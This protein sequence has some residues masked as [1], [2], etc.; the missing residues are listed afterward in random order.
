MAPSF[1]AAETPDQPNILFILADDLAWSDLGCYGHPWHDTPHLD[2]LASEGARFTEAYASAPIC[3]ASRASILTGKTPARLHF[4]FVT[5]DAAGQQKIDF[6]TPL[7]APP[8]TLN[9]PLE[10]RTI[11][12]CLN[13]EGYQTAFFG[14][15]HVSSHHER[16]LGWSP[17]HGPK[18][19]GFEVAEEDY[20]AHPYN[21]KR[22]PV[23]TITEVGSF[24]SDSMVDRVGAF[25]RKKHDRPYFAMASSFY[26][27]TPVRTPCQWLRKKYDAR[28]PSNSKK[29]KNRI[30]YAAFVET[31][32]HHV[33]QI[34]D[35]LE[36][37]GEAD[38]TIVV[39]YS[40]NGGHP[41]YTAN[42]P[43]RGSKWNLYEGGIRVPMIVRWPGVVQA[44][45]EIERP[46]IGVDLLPTMVDWA[47]GDLPKCD[48]ESVAGWMN[49]N[50]QSAEQERSLI[51]HFPYYHPEK[52][53]AKAPDNIGI[54][55]FAT[56]RT[57]PQSAI[58]RGQY[59]L[60]QFAEDNRVELYDLASDI[61]EQKDLSAQ[62]SDLAAKLQHEL[63]QTLTRQDARQPTVR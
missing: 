41:E 9:L 22:S 6:P 52:G 3:S 46:V 54:D 7:S 4:E 49:A 62:R 35:S 28:V 19:Q 61:G 45:T 21:W 55:D 37:S 31:F 59:K 27:H 33:G 44:E 57:R 58:R 2:E 1:A 34:L 29:R 51:W 40:D 15:W 56:S 16:Y 18:K 12:E 36:A 5:K 24:A 8:L 53:F 60:L 42:A 50:P 30:E 63:Q 43:L 17:T 11:A 32:D 25:L 26:V 10:E 13:D 38:R 20:G 47:G 14:K 23:E 39:F 48:G